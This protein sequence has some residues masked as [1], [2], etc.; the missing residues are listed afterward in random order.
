MVSGKVLRQNHLLNSWI[1]DS[2]KL[3]EI[4]SV[5]CYFKLISSGWLLVQQ[6]IINIAY[7][8]KWSSLYH[9]TPLQVLTPKANTFNSFQ[10]AFCCYCYLPLCF[11]IPCFYFFLFF[12]FRCYIL[13]SYYGR[14]YYFSPSE[15]LHPFPFKVITSYFLVIQCTYEDYHINTIQS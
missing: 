13:I 10:L 7:N 5:Y 6:K 15:I 9:F 1:S 11:Y 4:T 8:E 12:H 3:S 14:W 2:Q